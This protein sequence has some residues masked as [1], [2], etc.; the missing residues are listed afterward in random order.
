MESGTEDVKLVES[1]PVESDTVVVPVVGVGV[2]GTRL[3]TLVKI[4][5]L[6]YW[7]QKSTRPP[8]HKISSCIIVPLKK[9]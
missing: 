7:K 1:E 3:L 8:M 2:S 9:T 4:K 6:A 5:G